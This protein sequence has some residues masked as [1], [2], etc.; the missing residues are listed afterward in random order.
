[1]AADDGANDN[2]WNA[3]GVD[4]DEDDGDG[5][6]G[7]ESDEDDASTYMTEVPMAIPI[8]GDPL[9]QPAMQHF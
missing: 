5:G 9:A 8:V 2:S 7:N 4:D 6:D 3:D 1:M